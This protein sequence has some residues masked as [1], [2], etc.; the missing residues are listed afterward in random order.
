MSFLQGLQ[1]LLFFVNVLNSCIDNFIYPRD[2]NL[3]VVDIQVGEET[4][5]DIEYKDFVK[6]Y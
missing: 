1:I 5:E 4:K 2:I 6:A 3:N